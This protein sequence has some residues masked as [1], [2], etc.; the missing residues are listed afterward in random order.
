VVEELPIKIRW[1]IRKD[2]PDLLAVE[3]ACFEY[4][5]SLTD[6]LD[7]SRK[8][9]GILEAAILGDKI[10]GY[11]AYSTRIPGS[12]EG[13]M[14]LNSVAVLPEFQRR[15]VGRQLVRKLRKKLQQNRP[16]IL[17][18]VRETNLA[19]QLF[20]REV[21]FFAISVVRGFYEVTEEDAYVMQTTH[22]GEVGV[23]R[24]GTGRGGAEDDVGHRDF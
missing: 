14:Q 18:Q 16:R 4:P 20:F 15:G 5:W 3:D 10:I 17:L 12:Y 9:E 8:Q 11:M 7:H 22:S 1:C 6:F 24:G 19:A 23:R 13:G 21:G 2:F